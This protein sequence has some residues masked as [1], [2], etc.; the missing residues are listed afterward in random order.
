MQST[1]NFSC[2]DFNDIKSTVRG[3][4]TCKASTAHPTTT[5]GSSGTSSGTSSGSSSSSSAKSAAGV[6]GVNVPAVAITAAFGA[7]LQALL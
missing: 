1:G 4:F 2:S 7:M 6:I 5:D 3:S